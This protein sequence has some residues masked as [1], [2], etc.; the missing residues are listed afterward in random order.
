MKKNSVYIFFSLSLLLVLAIFFF[1]S[2]GAVSS[3][4]LSSGVTEMILKVFTNYENLDADM[5]YVMI[6]QFHELIRSL[7]HFSLFM[8]LG[9]FMY[10]YLNAKHIRR[11]FIWCYSICVIY[12]ICDE[13]HQKFFSEGRSFQLEDLLKDWSGSLVGIVLAAALI[14]VY[15]VIAKKWRNA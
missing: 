5:Q 10:L 14:L 8:M 15:R 3:D 11:K 6:V 13:L 7:A 9:F 12:A 1:S 2:Q 4:A